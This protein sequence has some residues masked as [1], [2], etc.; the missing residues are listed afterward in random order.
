MT[1]SKHA[2]KF[3]FFIRDLVS[4]KIGNYECITCGHTTKK[5]E[6]MYLHCWNNH[7]EFRRMTK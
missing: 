5:E 2:S 6:A 7:Q 3:Y 1:Y 4:N